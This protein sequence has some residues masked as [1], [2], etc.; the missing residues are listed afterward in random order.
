MRQMFAVRRICRGGGGGGG[1]G[2]AKQMASCMD[3][4]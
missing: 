4:R 1:G 2:L 3:T